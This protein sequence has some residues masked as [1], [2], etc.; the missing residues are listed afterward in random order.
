VP[1]GLINVT[2]KFVKEDSSLTFLLLKGIIPRL[3]H[4]LD[5]LD[6]PDVP[7]LEGDTRIEKI[8]VEKNKPRLTPG[9][10]DMRDMKNINKLEGIIF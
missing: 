5:V 7:T 3:S 8:E 2:V 1:C 6:V 4:V 10:G 9:S